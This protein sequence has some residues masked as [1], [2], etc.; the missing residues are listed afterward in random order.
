MA[1]AS[2]IYRVIDNWRGEVI[3]DQFVRVERC[4]TVKWEAM[5]YI[6]ENK[7][8]DDP[9]K[10]FRCTRYRDGQHVTPEY[11]RLV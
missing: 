8:T 2:Y 3:G 1:R 5:V 11:M 7:G 4:F 6:N 10:R 9:S